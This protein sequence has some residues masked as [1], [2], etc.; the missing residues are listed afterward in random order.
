MPAH[1]PAC[2]GQIL[3]ALDEA[4][5][6]PVDPL[7]HGKGQILAVLVGQCGDRHFGIGNIDA[8][9]VGDHP[10][11]FG[12]TMDF[13]FIRADH[14]EAD[15]AVVDQQPLPLLEQAEQFGM[16]QFDAGLVAGF[17]IAVEREM[18]RM[19]DHRLP[20]LE[21]ADAQL[22]TLQVG[23]DRDRAAELFLQ[24]ADRLDRLRMVGMFAMA[25]IDAEGVDPGLEQAGEHFGRPACR[26]DGGEDLDLAAA[27]IELGGGVGHDHRLWQRCATK[28]G[29]YDHDNECTRSA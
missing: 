10:A 26:T 16:R 13:L 19:A 28:Q 6:D 18:A 24:R 8:L 15:F 17:G 27:R 9:A 29:P 11:D 22:G 20:V 7:R 4:E 5:T 23:E 21:L 3:G 12:R 1:Q 25:H 14:P 2:F